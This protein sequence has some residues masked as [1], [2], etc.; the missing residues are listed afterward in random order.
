MDGVV[1]SPLE[2]DCFLET[3][4]PKNLSLDPTNYRKKR[5][6]LLDQNSGSVERKDMFFLQ[7]PPG[8]TAFHIRPLRRLSQRTAS[9]EARKEAP[10]VSKPK[11]IQLLGCVRKMML[12]IP[13]LR[14]M[15]DFF[16]VGGRRFS[17]RIY[18]P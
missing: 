10:G 14:Q 5:R 18:E 9:N 1:P 2:T 6:G 8:S 3:L 13:Y 7:K 17:L 15:C 4:S 12:G 11:K 16:V